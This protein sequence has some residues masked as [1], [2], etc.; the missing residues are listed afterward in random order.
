MPQPQN[1]EYQPTVRELR[2]HMGQLLGELSQGHAM[3]ENFRLHINLD[4]QPEPGEIEERMDVVEEKYCELY[5]AVG[6]L[7]GQIKPLPPERM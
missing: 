5:D 4:D 1:P 7:V 2:V 6:R 3:L